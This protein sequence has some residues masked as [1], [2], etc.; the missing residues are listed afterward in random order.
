MG[1]ITGRAGK[2]G[3]WFSGAIGAMHGVLTRIGRRSEHAAPTLCGPITQRNTVEAPT[4]PGRTSTPHS[5]IFDE[6]N[7]VDFW[8]DLSLRWPKGLPVH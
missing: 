8:L 4:H 3:V 7:D 5:A 1:E 6:L 2:A